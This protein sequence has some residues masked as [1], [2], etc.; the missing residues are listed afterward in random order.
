VSRLVLELKPPEARHYRSW[1]ERLH[2]V[3]RFSQPDEVHALCEKAHAVG[4][5]A[6]LAVVDPTIREALTAFQQWRDVPVWAVVPNMQ[7]FIRDLTDLGMVGAARARFFKLR[8][9]DMVRVGLRAA[10]Q[11]RGVL[12]KDFATG[13][14]LV[15]DMELA[16]LRGLRVSRLFLHPQATEVALAGGVK[17]CFTNLLRQ[18]ARLGVDAGI[19]T[20]NPVRAAAVLGDDFRRFAVVVSPCNPKGY[21]MFPGRDACEGLY[22]SDPTRFLAS[23]VT[24]SGAVPWAGGLAHVRALGLAGAMLDVHQVEEAFR[25]RAGGGRAA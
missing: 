12:K 17:A 10:A 8:P 14:N 2:A 3:A 21:K 13:V 16:G 6:V 9:A 24:A 20:N 19:V 23:E 4:A 11:V 25:G 22:R 5:S 18:A 1:R 7:A 15:A